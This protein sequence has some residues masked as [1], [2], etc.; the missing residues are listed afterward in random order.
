AAGVAERSGRGRERSGVE[1]LA[2]A[3]VA[4]PDRLAGNDVGPGGARYSAREIG[5][6]AE[7]ARRK[8]RS[9]SQRQVA[10]EGESAEDVLRPAVFGQPFL[11]FAEGKFIDVVGGEA[12]PLVKA[13]EPA[14]SGD[15]EIVLRDHRCPTADRRSVVDR[16]RINVGTT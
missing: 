11:F 2:N 13:G 5:G 3:P 6:V 9:R 16:F 8:R 1:P 7:D 4:D 14:F 10:A 15:I 12:L